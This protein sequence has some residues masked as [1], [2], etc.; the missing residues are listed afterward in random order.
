MTP[1]SHDALRSMER[2]ETLIA[3]S[4]RRTGTMEFRLKADRRQTMD[5]R[6]VRRGGRRP[7]DLDWSCPLRETLPRSE[8]A[9]P[10]ENGRTALDIP[11]K[12]DS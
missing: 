11:S 7:A 5:R 1:I 6:Q 12:S 9:G 3:W 10:F 8:F 4:A 2:A